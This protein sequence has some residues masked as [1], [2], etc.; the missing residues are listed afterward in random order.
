MRKQKVRDPGR[1]WVGLAYE[2]QN[3]GGPEEGGWYYPTF[4][5]TDGKWEYT[6]PYSVRKP[7][8]FRSQAVALA[9]VKKVQKM[10]DKANKGRRKPWSSLYTG[11]YLA[12]QFYEYMK[13]HYQPRRRPYYS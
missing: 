1:F 10:V 4:E 5:P 12:V 8:H 2:G 9:Y 7:R 6:L 3:Y 13:P 11:G